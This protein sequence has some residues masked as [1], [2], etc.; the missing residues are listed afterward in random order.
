[1]VFLD[2]LDLNA[3]AVIEPFPKLDVKAAI[4]NAEAGPSQWTERED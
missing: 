1:M 2:V 4:T 3:H